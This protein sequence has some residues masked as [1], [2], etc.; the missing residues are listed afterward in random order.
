MKPYYDH[1]GITIYHG[2]CREILPSL[3][4]VENTHIEPFVK[5]GAALTTPMTNHETELTPGWPEHREW[6]RPG[7]AGQSA[8]RRGPQ[9]LRESRLRRQ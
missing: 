9:S 2:D 3:P 5:K 8:H 1:A 4:K 6:C 7:I